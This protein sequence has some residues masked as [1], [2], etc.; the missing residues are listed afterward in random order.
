MFIYILFCL[1]LIQILVLFFVL[2]AYL[3]VQH[4][5]FK[6]RDQP[7]YFSFDTERNLNKDRDKNVKLPIG[8]IVGFSNRPD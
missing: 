2:F 8:P 7:G 5:T 3:N 6:F 1:G 4:A